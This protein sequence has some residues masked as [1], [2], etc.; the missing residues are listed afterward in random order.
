MML[1]NVLRDIFVLIINCN[2]GIWNS[3]RFL[4]AL[5]KK[6]TKTMVKSILKNGFAKVKG[7]TSKN[8]SKFD[9]IL[10][11][12]KKDNGYFAWDMEFE[13]EE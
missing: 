12:T 1:L 9:A 6:P 2:F 7:L 4:L 8:G 13:K 5:K 11:Y 10:K 3:D